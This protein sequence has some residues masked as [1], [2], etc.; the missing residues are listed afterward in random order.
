MHMAGIIILFGLLFL[1]KLMIEGCGPWAGD[2]SLLTVR[3]E[4]SCK[5]FQRRRRFFGRA[6]LVW[7]FL[8][9]AAVMVL[10][11]SWVMGLLMASVL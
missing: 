7:R 3:G 9:T 1:G 11:T 2:F 6:A 4:P 10:T 8:K 5:F